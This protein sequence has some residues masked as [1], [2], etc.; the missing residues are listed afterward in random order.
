[1]DREVEVAAEQGI[2]D[3]FTKSRL[4][5]DSDSGRL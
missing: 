4:V 1:V 5:P 3:L 2:L